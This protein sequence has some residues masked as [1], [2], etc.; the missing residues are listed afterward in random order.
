M[1]FSNRSR[2]KSQ[3]CNG[4]VFTLLEIK[5]VQILVSNYSP[6][7]LVMLDALHT[8]TAQKNQHVKRKL[9]LEVAILRKEIST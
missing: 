1:K 5:V 2:E 4:Q 8:D 3:E 7:S 9:L 6:P